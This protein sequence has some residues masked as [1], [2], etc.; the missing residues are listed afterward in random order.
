M[1][2]ILGTDV[3]FLF[4]YACLAVS[5]PSVRDDKPSTSCKISSI[6]EISLVG[7]GV[8]CSKRRKY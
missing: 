2:I 1:K 3:E 7:V 8:N 6:V 4:L 5:R